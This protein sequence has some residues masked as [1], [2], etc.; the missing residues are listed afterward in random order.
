MKNV[1]DNE[2]VG[3]VIDVKNVIMVMDMQD[4]VSVMMLDMIP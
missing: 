3:H 4:S 2:K 1:M